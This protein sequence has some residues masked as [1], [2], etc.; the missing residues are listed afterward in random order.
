[1]TEEQVMGVR[2]LHAAAD[3]LRMACVEAIGGRALLHIAFDRDAEQTLPIGD[4]ILMV[5]LRGIQ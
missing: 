3:R 5:Q 2:Q 1:M 4:E